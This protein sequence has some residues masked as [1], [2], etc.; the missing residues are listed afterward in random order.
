MK[1]GI[2]SSC[3]YPLETDKSLEFLCKNEIPVTEIFF[4]SPS[5]ILLPYVKVLENLS[6]TYGTEIS[7]VHPCG[8]VG[9]P[10]FLFSEYKKRY[11]ES[12]DYYNRYYEAAAQLGAK[13]VVLHGDTLQGSIPMGEYAERLM[14]MNFKANEYGVSVL[15]ENVNRYRAATP[16]NI[17]ELKRLTNGRLDFTYDVKQSVRAGFEPNEIYAA[18]RGNIKNVHISDNSLSGDCLLPSKGEF[19]FAT[20]FEELDKDRYKGAV[21]VEVYNWAYKDRSE[22]IDAYNFVKNVHKKC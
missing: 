1:L 20:L 8:S 19:D 10:Y 4:N 18:M 2:S 15:Q 17:A 7:S 12:F 21:L 5:E 14:E 13:Y 22:L 16:E 3:L 11:L 6:K 9:E